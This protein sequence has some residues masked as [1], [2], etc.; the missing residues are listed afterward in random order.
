[1]LFPYTSDVENMTTSLSFLLACVSTTS[2]P[3]TLVSMV[4]TG[5]STISLTPT[6]AARWNTTSARSMSSAVS[7]SFITVSITY[8]IQ[9]DL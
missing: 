1:M 3:W 6:A 5:A 4:R 8:R 2:V 9:D 7:G